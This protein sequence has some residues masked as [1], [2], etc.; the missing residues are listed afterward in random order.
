MGRGKFE[1]C[2]P[3]CSSE[4]QPY[5]CC[6]D[7]LLVAL[8]MPET[9]RAD[10]VEKLGDQVEAT[11]VAVLLW[12]WRKPEGTSP[13]PSPGALSSSP[14]QPYL[15]GC[16][17]SGFFFFLSQLTFLPSCTKQ[18]D[19]HTCAHT[20]TH[21]HVLFQKLRASTLKSSLT[22]LHLSP[23]HQPMSRSHWLYL[24]PVSQSQPLL[25][26]FSLLL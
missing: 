17:V 8:L 22:R 14:P 4:T 26:S 12:A 25:P 1:C 11:A 10:W 5:S 13:G 21:V 7:C 24:Q 9:L 20:H 3:T 6:H 19:R 16:H 2:L 23:G 15:P 18:T